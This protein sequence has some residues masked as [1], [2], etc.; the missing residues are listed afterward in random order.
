MIT[1]D[2]LESGESQ[3]QAEALS[4]RMVSF[5]SNPQQTSTCTNRQFG[6]ANSDLRLGV[7]IYLLQ[8]VH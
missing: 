1:A 7:S 2:D 6:P 4:T 8:L 3:K 5:T